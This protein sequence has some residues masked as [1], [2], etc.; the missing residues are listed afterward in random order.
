MVD[1]DANRDNLR[2]STTS[3]DGRF[4]AFLSYASGVGP[5]PPPPPPKIFEDKNDVDAR[6][7]PLDSEAASIGGDTI[8]TD[9]DSTRMVTL[10]TA[11][12]EGDFSSTTGT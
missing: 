1:G 7:P 5:A 11:T 4:E 2:A 6:L 8:A 10:A 3:S 12:R 9:E